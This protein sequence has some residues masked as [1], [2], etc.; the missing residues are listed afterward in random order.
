MGRISNKSLTRANNLNQRRDA[1]GR[2]GPRS[3]VSLELQVENIGMTDTIMDPTGEIPSALHF[4]PIDLTPAEPLAKPACGHLNIDPACDVC[5]PP[6]TLPRPAVTVSTETQTDI[7]GIGP[8]H[9][10]LLKC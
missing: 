2:A 8:R 1:N 5:H 3:T 9:D 4:G 7:Q 10:F 6:V